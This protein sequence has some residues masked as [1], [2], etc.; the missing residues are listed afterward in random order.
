METAAPSG[1]R[2]AYLA[3]AAICVIWGTTFAA[4]RVTIETIPVLLVTGIRFTIAGLLLFIIARLTGARFPSDRSEWRRQALAG[5]MMAGCANALVVFAERVLNSGLAALLAATIPIWMAVMESI[6]G[7]ARFTRRKILALTLGFGGVAVL[8]APAI[9]RPDI[10]GPF[11][12]AVAAMQ[13]NAI[14]WN[15][16]TLISRRHGTTAD[17][18]ARSVIQMLTAGPA[19]VLLALAIGERPT[20]AMWS[21]RSTVALLYLA[22]F[23]SVIAYWAYNYAQTKLS[24]GKVAS[25]AYVNPAVAVLF[26][27]LV[28]SEPV[29]WPMVA[30]MLM[31]LGGVALIQLDRMPALRR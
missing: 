11:L 29:T 10:S 21:L 14:F 1:H 12:I 3:F 22:I 26:G 16:G 15:W 5:L 19:V 25:Y 7:Q 9:G 8:V 23:G 24:A 4:I 2:L 13:V 30:A 6:A 17:P 31:I 27:A 18:T 20:L 28:L